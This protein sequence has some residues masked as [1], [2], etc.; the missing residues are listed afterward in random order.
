MRN[1]SMFFSRT[2]LFYIF[3]GY[4][5]QNEINNTKTKLLDMIG[6]GVGPFNLGLAALLSNIQNT[7]Y[8][9]LDKKPSFS[10]HEYMMIDG[11]KLQV[12]YLKDL[13]TLLDPTNKFSFLAY[14]RAQKRIH[15]FIN[16]KTNIVTR[17]EFSHYYQWVSELID[18]IKFNQEVQTII[19]K[20]NK[21]ILKTD[22]HN[23]TAQNVVIGVGTTPYIEDKFKC[24]LGDNVFHSANY[25]KH[26]IKLDFK[27]KKIIIVGGGQSGAEIFNDIISLKDLPSKITWVTR[28]AHFQPLEDSC[29]SNEFYTPSYILVN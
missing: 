24:L 3:L 16:R 28:R 19:Y 25:I 17:E 21:F 23:Y 7:N 2:F 29:F 27:N 8:I 10:W 12:H 1:S 26:K 11:A 22:T 6:V 9:F 5:M 15:Q 4:S 20:D 18:G 14:L 13:V